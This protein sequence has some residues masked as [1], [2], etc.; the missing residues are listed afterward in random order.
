MVTP[1]ASPS[2][3]PRPWVAPC[4]RYARQ[5]KP[6]S[7]HFEMSLKGLQAN[8]QNAADTYINTNKSIY[9][10]ILYIYIY[11]YIN[12]ALWKWYNSSVATSHNSHYVNIQACCS[13]TVC[14]GVCPADILSARV[15]RMFFAV[16]LSLWLCYISIRYHLYTSS[17]TTY[18][19]NNNNNN[20]F[21]FE[22]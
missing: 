15:C 12:S 4:A 11:L 10:Y 3:K 6:R 19:N 17:P 2:P 21:G 14:S 5:S 9:I 8:M 20:C 1:V 22:K 13:A 18:S 16:H 7:K